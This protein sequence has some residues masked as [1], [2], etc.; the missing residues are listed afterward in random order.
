[1]HAFRILLLLGHSLVLTTLLLAQ[2]PICT[3]QG[4][5]TFSALDGEVHTTTG[6]ITAIHVGSG[7]IQ[8]YF[9]EDP[10]CDAS[11]T[12]SNGLFI[13][14]PNA[15]GLSVGQRVQV[16]GTVDEFQGLTELRSITNVQVVGTGTVAPTAITLPIATLNNWERYEGMLLRFP[17]QLVVT[18]TRNWI[19]YGEVVL[20][21]ERL[22]FPTEVV[23]PNDAVADNT[24]STG[25]A[26]ATAVQAR[27]ALND[28]S[29]IL[30]DDGRTISYPEPPPLLGPQG[31]LRTGSTVTGLT[32]V[33][34]YAFDAFR[35]HPAGTVPLVHAPR[36]TVPE[37]DG[38]ITLASLNV[39]NY[40]T[41]LD[42]W[43]AV[44]SAELQ[45]QRTKL[46]AALQAL[47][48]DALVLCELENNDVAWADLLAALNTAVGAGTYA[49]READASGS[50]GTKTVLFY[51]PAVLTP[52]GSL[53]AL[54]TA[55]FQRPHLT[56]AFTVNGTDAR[57]LLSSVHLRSKL[58]DNATGLNLD[59]GD[60]Q[61]CFNALRR[62]QAMALLE[63]WS[64]VRT[65][66][67]VPVQVVLGDFNAYAQEDPI[68]RL[69]AGGLQDLL[70]AEA[71][72]YR[73]EGTFGR[74]DHGFG[75]APALAAMAGAA[76][77]NLNGDE[78]S[79]LDY[80]EE[81]LALYQPGPYRSADHDAVVVG[82]HSDL[83]GVGIAP[84]TA[85]DLHV[86]V[87]RLPDG[88]RWTSSANG[89]FHVEAYDVQGRLLFTTSPHVEVVTHSLR[90]VASQV[91][92]WRAVRTDGMPIG[93]G[94]VQWW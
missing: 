56:Q 69:R 82:L 24:T 38:D 74:L 88:I 86:H 39:L 15:T 92:L 16:T 71:Y 28:R 10:T 87:Q 37:V 76:M 49:A 33:L 79:E 51:K 83:I 75:T 21:T 89:P 22:P 65:S 72:S 5:G 73:Y 45:R 85:S 14:Q 78:P 43:G 63:H 27:F 4:S 26:N 54:N 29:R 1:M 31:T 50:G 9:I 48:A 46:V 36:P 12:T 23:D 80:R 57:F 20:A 55:I 47:D 18:D 3:I 7:T 35:L 61:G 62:D 64:E 19:Q 67:G 44:T 53:Q 11:A 94:R 32:A 25:T 17:Q 34:S 8:G 52:Q 41:T 68:D 77:W 70:P 66:T 90:D 93:E 60:G 91:L 6:I 42:V 40:F 84:K 13:Y 2:T 30:L 58:C 59:Q 81:N